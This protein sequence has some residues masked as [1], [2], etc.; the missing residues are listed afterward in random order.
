[1][2]LLRTSERHPQSYLSPVARSFKT[3]PASVAL[4]CCFH[5]VLP[6]II[7]G[8]AAPISLRAQDEAVD[9]DGPWISSIAW[10]DDEQIVG[11]RSQGLLLRP[12]DVVTASVTDPTALDVRTELPSSLWSVL[13]TETGILTTDYQGG[14]HVV[15]DESIR[16][17]EIEARW[18]RATCAT[19][20]S[21]TVLCGTEDGKLVALP[22]DDGADQRSV[23]AHAAGI[24]DIVM[25]SNHDLIATA[26]GDGSIGLFQWPSLEKVGTLSNGSSEAVWCLQFTADGKHLVS[27]GADRRL[28]LWDVDA[29][30]SV[31]TMTRAHDWITDLVILPDASLVAATCMDGTLIVAD[32]ELKTRIAELPIAESAL[33]C[34]ALSPSKNRLAF[35]TRKHG[36]LL[37]TVGDWSAER[38]ELAAQMA[39]QRPPAPNGE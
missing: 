4:R 18:I 13:P 35:G 2:R 32:Y 14:V 36:I 30:E 33:W 7:L 1:M 20:E 12:A 9:A 19:P 27:G 21:T 29:R 22:L 39:T 15:S 25:N 37:S 38:D 23:D 11:T 8:L 17:I 26:C 3:M 16:R 31:C 5:I 10:L 28:Q 34:L 6:L 24:F